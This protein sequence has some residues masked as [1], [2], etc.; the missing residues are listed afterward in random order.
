MTRFLVLLLV[1][2]MLTGC[3]KKT[4]PDSTE[5]TSVSET[6][7]EETAD[8][9]EPAT[10]SQTDPAEAAAAARIEEFLEE[11]SQYYPDYEILDSVTGS[12]ENAPILMA[13]IAK[14]TTTGNASTLF[15][16]D[17]SGHGKLGLAADY[18]AFYRSEDGIVLEGNAILLSLDVEIAGESQKDA[19][20]YEIHDFKI[21]V[22]QETDKSGAVNTT[23]AN[24]ETIRSTQTP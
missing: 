21:S 20:S 19:A 9:Q 14:D 1:I 23:Y 8:T 11:F 22:T 18:N 2:A 4:A 12:A 3:S 15:V 5:T 16:L 10:E 13:V 7:A 24:S 17:E 6:A